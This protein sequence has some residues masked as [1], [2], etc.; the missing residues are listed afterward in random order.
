MW[1]IAYLFLPSRRLK[2]AGRKKES[3]DRRRNPACQRSGRRSLSSSHA[4]HPYTAR[5][6]MRLSPTL[7]T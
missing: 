7:N 2:A 6:A 3:G 1:M 5:I 4:H